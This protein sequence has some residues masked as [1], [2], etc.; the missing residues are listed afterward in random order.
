[1]WRPVFS[2]ASCRRR[3][4]SSIVLPS[5]KS[6][7]TRLASL[8]ISGSCRWRVPVSWSCNRCHRSR[9]LT[10]A[11]ISLARWIWAIAASP[12]R[13]TS[14]SNLVVGTRTVSTVGTLF[15]LTGAGSMTARTGSD[16]MVSSSS[17]S[18][19][20]KLAS[21]AMVLSASTL[22]RLLAVRV[23]NITLRASLVSKR[24]SQ[25][26]GVT[27]SLFFCSARRTSSIE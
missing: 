3:L 5:S 24:A 13:F 20:I 22:I 6:W 27:G 16:T 14:S 11:S 12:E 21:R 4:V 2:A 19:G 26:S 1:M 7:V 23:S 25:A 8:S 15:S 9:M 10:R 18:P 17:V